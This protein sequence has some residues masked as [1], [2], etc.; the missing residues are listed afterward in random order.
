MKRL[1]RVLIA[2]DFSEPAMAAFERALALS[3]SHGAELSVV[4]AVP[5][6]RPF[7][8]DAAERRS[9]IG[10]LRQ[11]AA[12]AG[13]PIDVS[14]QQGDPAGVILLH[15]RAR[16]PDLIVVG[17]SGPRS[18]LDRIRLGSVAET[19]AAK[20]TEPVL[21]IP[22]GSG[23]TGEPEM[24]FN[25]LLVALDFSPGS[26]AI[27]ETAL[28]MASASSRVTLLHVTPAVPADAT[29]RYMYRLM[30]PEYQRHLVRDAWRRIS[31]IVPV[32]GRASRNV[33]ARV[34]TGKVSA[35]ISRIADDVS[36]DVILVGVTRR[37][38]FGRLFGSTAVRVIRTA[39]RPVLAIPQLA[40]QAMVPLTNEERLALAA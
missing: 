31:Q 13:V 37:G 21:V 20:A 39:G 34:V 16:R 24:R 26:A 18:A 11:A 1:D 3:R 23:K 7:N 17:T 25:N 33:H 27:V 28:S 9:H 10:A 15:A 19:V 35:E 22:A 14:I 8:W 38:V 30:E 2:T 32:E 40:K 36:A 12:A 29:P 4:H 5:T 6:T